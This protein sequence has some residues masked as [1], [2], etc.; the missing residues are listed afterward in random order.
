MDI[1][2]QRAERGVHA[3][4]TP[5]PAA[6]TVTTSAALEA[7]DSAQEVITGYRYGLALRSRGRTRH[8]RYAGHTAA[9]L[10]TTCLCRHY[11]WQASLE[12]G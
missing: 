4:S 1:S 11:Y 7:A 10:P 2:P 5:R 6:P 8:I 3:P 9:R 12:A